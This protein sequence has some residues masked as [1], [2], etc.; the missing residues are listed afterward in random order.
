MNKKILF[1]L[2]IVL[3][4][5]FGG[6]FA[7]YY[8][9]TERLSPEDVIGKMITKMSKVNSFQYQGDLKSSFQ[10]PE[11]GENSLAFSFNGKIDFKD[12]DNIKNQFSLNLNTDIT[13]EFL[14]T[15]FFLEVEGKGINDFFYFKLNDISN[16]G[17]FSLAPLKNIWIEIDAREQMREMGLEEEDYSLEEE[18]IEKIVNQLIK[19]FDVVEVLPSVKVEGKT[20]YNYRIAYNREEFKKF[21]TLTEE[22]LEE[23]ERAKAQYGALDEDEIFNLL[24]NFQ[25]R[26]LIGEK[27][28]LLYGVFLEFTGQESIAE[29]NSLN[30]NLSMNSFNQTFEIEAPLETRT[31]EEVLMDLFGGFTF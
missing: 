9:S 16:I 20:A 22:I 4:I 26:V 1:P 13:E 31:M 25:V 18:E 6:V 10:N 11:G 28:F 23:N 5:I 7:Y 2:V 30:F 8:T 27:D 12:E 19:S 17:F 29:L 24:E 3:V 21:L 15:S 14:G